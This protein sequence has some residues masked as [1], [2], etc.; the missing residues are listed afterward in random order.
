MGDQF[1]PE[2]VE[3]HSPIGSLVVVDLRGRKVLVPDE[4]MFPNI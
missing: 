3:R 1:D 4:S 2:N